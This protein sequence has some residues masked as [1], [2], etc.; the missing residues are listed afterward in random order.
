MESIPMLL[1]QLLVSPDSRRK[2]RDA[3]ETTHLVVLF[4]ITLTDQI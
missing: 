1:R 2:I 4:N 3:L